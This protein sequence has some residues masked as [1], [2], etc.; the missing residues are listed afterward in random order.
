MKRILFLLLLSILLIFAFVLITNEIGTPQQG[1]AEVQQETN[2]NL[3][4]DA[5]FQTNLAGNIFQG[6]ENSNEGV[7]TPWEQEISQLTS[8]SQSITSTLYELQSGTPTFTFNFTHSDQGCNW[9]GVAGQVLGAGGAPVSGLVVLITGTLESQNIWFLGLTGSSLA[10]GPGGY[11]ISLTNHMV[12]SQGTLK[13]QLKDLSG[14]IISDLISFDTVA[15]CQ[16][17]Q[18]IINFVESGIYKKGYF[19]IILRRR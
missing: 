16:K 17:N 13:I 11:D 1:I 5:Y 6:G 2:P 18:V 14:N 4:Q 15:D 10:A 8:H 3:N 19:P 12:A 9:T 7:G